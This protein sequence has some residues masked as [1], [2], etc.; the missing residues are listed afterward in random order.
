M[1]KIREKVGVLKKL[2]RELR[3]EQKVDF[4]VYAGGI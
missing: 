3:H 1:N 4:L 2:K